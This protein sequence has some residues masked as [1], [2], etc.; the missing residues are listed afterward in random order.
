M[1]AIFTRRAIFAVCALAVTAVG[2]MAA[3]AATLAERF[4]ASSPG[5]AGTVDHAAWD[6]L[7]QRYVKAADDGVNRVDYAAFKAQ[8]HAALKAY[9]RALESVSPARLSSAEQMAYWANLYNAKT[10][11]IVLDHY[12][13]GS[14]RDISIG[15]GL[16]G[17]LKKSVGAG[18][19]WKAKVVTVDGQALSLDNIEHDILRPVFKDARVH[20]AVNCASYG[21]PNLMREA[22]TGAKLDEQL[23]AGAR[24]FVNHP[25]G[26]DVRDG[27]VHASSIYDW[28]KIDFGGSDAGVLA[29]VRKFASP[30]TAAKLQGKAAI[31]GFAYDWRLNDVEG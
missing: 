31:D 14:I 22:F 23:D 2:P 19:P 3:R 27:K 30:Q 9:V 13:V 17:F 1:R 26:I 29:H 4:A 7:L 8:G 12:P 28:F 11:D 21:C 20:Y 24:A 18:G 10:I 15:E 5:T 6:S 16:F 25:R